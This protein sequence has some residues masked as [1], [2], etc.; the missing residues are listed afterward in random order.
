MSSVK[1]KSSPNNVVKAV[2]AAENAAIKKGAAPSPTFA[3]SAKG[4]GAET[5][6]LV[7]PLVMTATAKAN[8]RE[9][10]EAHCKASDISLSSLFPE[11]AKVTA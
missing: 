10:I 1:A 6:T 7:A 5:V 4:K 11:L 9:A 3:T 8:L 2:D